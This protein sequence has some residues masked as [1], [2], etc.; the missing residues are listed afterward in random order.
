MTGCSCLLCQPVEGK[1]VHEV[2]GYD[3]DKVA[4]Q[5]C[6]ICKGPIGEEAFLEYLIY[7]R[8]GQMMF[9]H[10][11]CASED[12]KKAHARTAAKAKVRAKC[13]I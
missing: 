5:E 12:F 8:F 6:L 7:A 13:R 3:L 1:R 11:R 10:A 4:E 9:V 2:Y